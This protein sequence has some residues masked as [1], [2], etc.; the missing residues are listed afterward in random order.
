[1]RCQSSQ[2]G[3]ECDH[4]FVKVSDKV[5]VEREVFRADNLFRGAKRQHRCWRKWE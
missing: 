2:L 1:L 5:G 4:V 3:L